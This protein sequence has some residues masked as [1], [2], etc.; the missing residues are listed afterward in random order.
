MG[1]ININLIK[2]K[3]EN[4][5]SYSI[6]AKGKHDL[7]FEIQT[8]LERNALDQFPDS[9]NNSCRLELVFAFDS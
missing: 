9:K 6:L 4:G 5:S 8:R 3:H 7:C 2:Y 1:I